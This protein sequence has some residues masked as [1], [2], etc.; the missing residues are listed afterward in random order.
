LPGVAWR[1]RLA[2]G[3]AS[4]NEMSRAVLIDH[5]V[6]S[7]DELFEPL[8]RRNP[9]ILLTAELNEL[10]RHTRQVLCD[11]LWLGEPMHGEQSFAWPIH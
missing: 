11:S 3:G 7:I 6:G 10:S 5:R 2:G 8:V 1:G 4:E 9:K